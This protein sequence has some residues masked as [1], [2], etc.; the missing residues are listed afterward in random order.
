MPL[1]TNPQDLIRMYLANAGK[2]STMPVPEGMGDLPGRMGDPIKALQ[3]APLAPGYVPGGGSIVPS[4]VGANREKPSPL[5]FEKMDFTKVDPP[6]TPEEELFK[7]PEGFKSRQQT[8]IERA[9]KA[10]DEAGGAP[11]PEGTV[12]T[13]VPEKAPPTPQEPHPFEGQHTVNTA[14]N[15]PKDQKAFIE[16]ITPHAEK[17]AAATGL[18]INLVIAKI[19]LET[20]YGQHAPGHNYFGIKETDPK[21]G[22]VLATQEMVDGKM[23]PRQER[24][25]TYANLDESTADY[26]TFL[27]SNSRYAELLKAKGLEA[28]LE[29]L[30][31]S[32]YATD[33][34][35][36]NKIRKIIPNLSGIRLPSVPPI[37]PSATALPPPTEPGTRVGEH[38]QGYFWNGTSWD[39]AM[40]RG[41]H[42]KDLLALSRNY[43]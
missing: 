34:D 16:Q 42:I 22:Q 6:K 24:F 38:K 23:V 21:K 39:K 41:G 10:L 32:G 26:I 20:G 29:A 1:I 18:D 36:V 11:A 35:Y 25:R 43:R 8:A 27:K 28:Q 3:Q 5:K 14:G 15:T 4:D 12:T 7:T 33:K 9:R 40:A 2:P 31:K 37:P 30:D 19:A 17:I 13:G